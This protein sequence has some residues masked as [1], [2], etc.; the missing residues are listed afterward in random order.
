[1]RASRCATASLGSGER[2]GLRAQ[3]FG[4]AGTVRHAAAE[5]RHSR[6][7]RLHHARGR[8][9]L[10]LID[11]EFRQNPRNHRLFLE[12]LRAPVGVTHELRRMNT[13]GVLGRY[14]P[15]F[16]RIVGR[17]QYD[18]FH[19]YTVDAHTLFVVSNLRR[20]A[21]SALRPRAAGCVARHAAA[22]Q[23]ARSPTSRRCSTTS[24]RAAAGITRSS[25]RWTPRPSASSRDCRATT[26]AWWPGWCATTWSSRSPRR[27][28]TSATRRSSTPSR[29]RWAMRRTWII[30]TC[31]P[32]PTCAARIRS[33]GTP[34]RR[35]CSATS[36]SA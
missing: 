29:A 35:R 16:G 8:R 6:R 2:G 34:G 3:P 33:C 10:W 19:A 25:A 23:D 18:L 36:T 11:E 9:N 12:I 17:M 21:M 32:A 31:S 26:R 4:A 30:C 7:A 27:S 22:A 28:R 1:M 20:L 5:P 15:A 24:P 14:I 13:Y